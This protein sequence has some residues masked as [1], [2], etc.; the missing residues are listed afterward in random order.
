M[1]EPILVTKA[2]GETVPFE[3]NKLRESLSNSGAPP[4]TIEYIV[5]QVQDLLYPGIPTKKIYQTAF[6]YLKRQK[7]ASAARYK[8]KRAIMEL[9]PSGYPFEKFV[10][11]LIH[12][13]GYEVEVGVTEM[14]KCVSHEIDVLGEKGNTRIAVE[15]KFGNSHDKKVDVR[16]SLYIHSRFKD[17]E[18]AWLT[19]EAHAHKTCQGWIVTNGTFSEDALR[20]GNCMGLHLV[21]WNYPE[22]NGN[23]KDWID[24]CQLY[25]I[26]S[27]TSLTKKEKQEFI[28]QGFIMCR[29]L[30]STEAHR[31]LDELRIP[32]NRRKKM[33][34]EIFGLCG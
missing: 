20:Y 4:S 5:N 7:N 13:Q 32:N 9:G 18:A 15:C 26:T 28:D 2:S 14:G 17:L 22:S 24:T 31:I 21:S 25:P 6:A 19:Q 11:E 29:D 23:L 16:V 3:V 8:L 34:A 33:E 27:L 10:G 30:L 12:N 1:S